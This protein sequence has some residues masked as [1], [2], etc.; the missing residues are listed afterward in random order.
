M[1]KVRI[2]KEQLETIVES[3]LNNGQPQAVNEFLGLGPEE[4]QMGTD[5]ASAAIE[6]GQTFLD[7]IIV[8]ELW[9]AA[10]NFDFARLKDLYSKFFQVKAVVGGIGGI[11][12]IGTMISWIVRKLRAYNKSY[13]GLKY[14]WQAAKKSGDTEKEKEFM[15]KMIAVKK[16][17][18]A[19]L[20]AK[21][22]SSS[23]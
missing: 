23:N 1:R 12:V 18:Q 21:I 17:A 14:E 16:E 9:D 4:I 13:A 2:T 10:K 6:V 8:Q 20:D 19:S 22:E 15:G 7:D 5:V 11:A 3:T